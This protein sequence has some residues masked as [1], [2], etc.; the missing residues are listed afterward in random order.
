MMQLF[1]PS[2]FS[3]KVYLQAYLLDRASILIWELSS[4]LLKHRVAINL[5]HILGHSHVCLSSFFFFPPS[6]LVLSLSPEEP[7]NPL[8]VLSHFTYQ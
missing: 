3:W 6:L 5:C 7:V 1:F 8:A 4:I 2:Y